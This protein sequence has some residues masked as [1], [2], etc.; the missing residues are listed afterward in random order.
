V[1]FCSDDHLTYGFEGVYFDNGDGR[2]AKVRAQAPV[3]G[4]TGPCK[5]KLRAFAYP[6]AFKD[7]SQPGGTAV[8]LC[9]N[10]N[11]GALP[12]TQDIK[13]EI[14]DW[15]TKGNLKVFSQGI[16]VLGRYLS[17][18][19]IH[20]LMHVADM[21]QCRT[22]HPSKSY[23]ELTSATGPAA[24]PDGGIGELYGYQNIAGHAPGAA[25]GSPPT[26]NN[27]QHNADSFAFLACGM[28][29]SS[30]TSSKT[31][32]KC[33]AAWYLNPIKWRNGVAFYM[34][35]NNPNRPPATL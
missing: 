9:S 3:P 18:M 4:A 22:L 8:I 10:W 14:G 13:G 34:N 35:E 12:S 32:A 1:I 19:I 15:R 28:H 29:Y 24:L 2:Q 11:E 17:Y 23:G 6:F 21:L 25:G 20:E 7:G 30:L 16:D 27:R 26:V 31:K 33:C 5:N